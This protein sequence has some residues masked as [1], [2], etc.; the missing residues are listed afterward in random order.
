MLRLIVL[1][2][3]DAETGILLFPECFDFS[4]FIWYIAHTLYHMIMWYSE[5][6][7]AAGIRDSVTAP[8]P[9][10]G[11]N[12]WSIKIRQC[13]RIRDGIGTSTNDHTGALAHH[14]QSAPIRRMCFTGQHALMGNK[15]STTLSC[16]QVLW[17]TSGSPLFCRQRCQL[18][19]H[20]V[21][22]TTEKSYCMRWTNRNFSL[23]NAH[24]KQL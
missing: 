15:L 10:L 4:L 11:G 2:C 1:L 17:Q 22:T 8:P 9:L 13:I 20:T 21:H 23:Y 12:G 19:R 16:D 7:S 3:A 14:I 18:A 5:P 6:F 24:G